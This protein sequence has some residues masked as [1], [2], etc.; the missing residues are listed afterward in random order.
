[1]NNALPGQPGHWRYKKEQSIKKFGTTTIK[2]IVPTEEKKVE[3]IAKINNLDKKSE[4]KLKE[5]ARDLSDDG[6]LNHST[7]RN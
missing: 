1:M 7:K 4:E 5:I 3:E 6:K 2:D